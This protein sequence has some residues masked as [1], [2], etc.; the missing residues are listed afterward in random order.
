MWNLGLKRA[1]HMWH[2]QNR[3]ETLKYTPRNHVLIR[4]KGNYFTTVPRYFM[5][6]V[7]LFETSELTKSSLVHKKCSLK[8]VLVIDLVIDANQKFSFQRKYFGRWS[9]VLVVTELVTDG[10]LCTYTRI[11]TAPWCAHQHSLPL[12]QVLKNKYY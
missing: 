3:F 6:L 10:C 4:Y 12:P 1:S 11:R 5:L 8:A 9:R 7:H 2:L